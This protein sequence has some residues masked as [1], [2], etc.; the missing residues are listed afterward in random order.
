MQDIL[1][2][3]PLW[4]IGGALLVGIGLA[5]AHALRV[6]LDF[7]PWGDDALGY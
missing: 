3:R 4:W 5:A 2:S 6:Q 7:D 1:R